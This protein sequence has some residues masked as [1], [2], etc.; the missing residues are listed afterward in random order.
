MI[1]SKGF[2][3]PNYTQT[4]ND[5]FL[6]VPDMEET[7]L[8]VTLVMIRETFG[9]KRPT[10]KLGV[11]EIRKRSG[12]SYQ[13]TL[14][15]IKAAETRGTFYRTNPESKKTA[16]WALVMDEDLPLLSGGSDLQPL[17]EEPPL[18]RPQV[19]TKERSKE[20]TKPPS[21]S[22]LVMNALESHFKI[23][24]NM[25]FKA[26]KDFLV[27]CVDTK[28]ITAEMIAYA[29]ERWEED[30]DINWNGKRKPS[31]V[32]ITET[33]PVLMEGFSPN[34]TQIANTREAMIDMGGL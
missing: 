28:N 30:P 25:T 20:N 8:R 14:N 22:S 2:K 32:S 19:P 31:I 15:G 26:H 9:W 33:W 7:E 23:A 29:A 6:M 21:R 34:Q 16:E 17:E 1:T 24:L 3:S 12:L 5:F 10:F 27:W 4:P 18:V 11:D 13:G